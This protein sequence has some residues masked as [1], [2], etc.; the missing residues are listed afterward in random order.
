MVFQR[1]QIIPGFFEVYCGCM[2]SGKTK[3]LIDRIDGIHFREDGDH[4]FFK[5]KIDTREL[6]AE[7]EE[8][9]IKEDKWE[10]QEQ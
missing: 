10:K 7:F 2:K 1:Q 5:P 3:A 9:K 8:N 4:I 6:L